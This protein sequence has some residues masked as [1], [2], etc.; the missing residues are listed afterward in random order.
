MPAVY[1]PSVNVVRE[2]PAT[3]IGTGLQIRESGG[4]AG[5]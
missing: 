3:P 4:V 1:M 2:K 5:V